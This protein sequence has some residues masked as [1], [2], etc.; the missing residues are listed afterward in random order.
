MYNIL[1]ALWLKNAARTL[2][3]LMLLLM[4]YATLSPDPGIPSG[5]APFIHLGGM[6][7]LAVLACMSFE[8]AKI[9][10]G[11]VFFVFVYSALMEIFQHYLPYRHG[12][13]E[14]VGINAVGCLIGVALFLGANLLRRLYPRVSTS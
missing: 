7:W 14:D 10:S 5:S 1:Y 9:R 12:T 11:A 13:W 2:L 6:A 4:P 8:T 3:V